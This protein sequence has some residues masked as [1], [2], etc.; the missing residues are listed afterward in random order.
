M[1][2]GKRIEQ[3]NQL[4]KEELSQI[5]LREVELPSGILLTLTQVETSVDLR[6]AKVFISVIPE[7]KREKVLEEV[8]RNIYDLQQKLNKRLN[9]RPV[10]KIRF[11]EEKETA[12]TEPSDEEIP[13]RYGTVDEAIHAFPGILEGVFEEDR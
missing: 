12:E 7:N 8:K 6:Q 2:M 10:P 5:I 11:I 4:I 13:T 1:L 3:V 9:M